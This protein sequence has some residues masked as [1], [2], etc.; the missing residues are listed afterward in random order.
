MLIPSTPKE[1][2][3]PM[4]NRTGTANAV[5]H[6]LQ[7]SAPSLNKTT[8]AAMS[9]LIAGSGAP[10]ISKMEPAPLERQSA[11]SAKSARVP[12]MTK[13]EVII[14]ALLGSPNEWFHILTA[15]KRRS[16]FGFSGMGKAFEMTT[17]REKNKIAHYARFTGDMDKVSAKGLKMLNR[18]NEKLNAIREGVEEG[19]T[20]PSGRTL[21]STTN[22][23]LAH[24]SKYPLNAVER[25][26]LTLVDTPNK[27]VLLTENSASN[28]VWHTFRW[29]WQTR[30]GF[31]LSQ[32]TFEQEKQPNGNYNLYGTYT[33][34]V[35]GA[36]NPG[37]RDFVAFLHTKPST[38]QKSAR[39]ASSISIR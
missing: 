6:A 27:R 13:T 23:S 20:A 28:E 16:D 30:Y 10:S 38:A 4:A 2:P 35:G 18:I 1:R 14:L 31:D 9:K 24:A 3:P 39:S 34:K 36:M 11:K 26:F 29:K 22:G 25:A 17:R 7:K 8:V 15:A 37:L 21:K 12:K 33:P 32:F 5:I 19:V